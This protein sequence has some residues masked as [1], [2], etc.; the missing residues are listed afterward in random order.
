MWSMKFHRKKRKFSTNVWFWF[1]TPMNETVA[2]TF[3]ENGRFFLAV[4]NPFIGG[5]YTCNINSSSTATLCIPSNSPLKRGATVLADNVEGR[6]SL[7]G[8]E[9]QTTKNKET[10]ME[11]Q[12]QMLQA[13]NSALAG[14]VKTLQTQQTA[15]TQMARQIQMLQASNSALAAHVKTLQS[16]HTATTLI[17]TAIWKLKKQFG[18]MCELS[19]SALWFPPLPPPH[20]PPPPPTDAELFNAELRRERQW[21]GQ[22]A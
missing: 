22:R 21:R 10:Q 18:Q 20:R 2:S 13:N 5:N 17:Q 16:Q 3:Q 19:L 8:S 11:R 9:M 6:I 14:H 1:Q 15:T 4:P 12:I 7:V